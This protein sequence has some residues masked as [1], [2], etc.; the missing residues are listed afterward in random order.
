MKVEHIAFW[1]ISGDIKQNSS[2]NQTV[3]DF[4]FPH[5]WCWRPK[6]SKMLRCF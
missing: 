4:K 5:W 3:R 2:Q 6:S 1:F